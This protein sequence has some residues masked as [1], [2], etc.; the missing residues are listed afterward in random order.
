MN[1][2]AMQVDAS[3]PENTAIPSARRALAPVA[4]TSGT[5]PSMNANEVIMIGLGPRA[6]L[7]FTLHSITLA[8]R[9][10]MSAVVLCRRYLPH[11]H[12]QMLGR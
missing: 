10:M 9:T 1:S 8:H 4:G 7:R 11:I 2:T 6:I 5:T 3:I 12:M